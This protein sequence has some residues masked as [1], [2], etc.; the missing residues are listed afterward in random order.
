MIFWA[1]TSRKAI[2]LKPDKPYD[3]ILLQMIMMKETMQQEYRDLADVVNDPKADSRA[4]LRALRKQLRLAVKMFE[5]S[6]EIAYAAKKLG[7]GEENAGYR[8]NL[9]DVKIK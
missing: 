7:Y 9:D 6:M 1:E 2:R 3:D 4:Q 5:L 8:Q